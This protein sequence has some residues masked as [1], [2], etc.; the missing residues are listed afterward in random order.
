M[1]FESIRSELARHRVALT[2]ETQTLVRRVPPRGQGA[3]FYTG[4]TLDSV[5]TIDAN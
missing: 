4:P 3:H 2:H 5:L 1:V